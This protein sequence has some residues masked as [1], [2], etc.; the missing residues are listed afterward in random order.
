MSDRR[1]SQNRRQGQGA[2]RL[3]RMESNDR[4][5]SLFWCREPGAREISA[6]KPEDHGP[7]FVRGGKLTEWNGELRYRRHHAEQDECIEHQTQNDTSADVPEQVPPPGTG[8][9][10]STCFHHRAYHAAGRG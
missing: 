10:L 3:E 8:K 7:K 5:S 4:V 2:A 1:R 9:R 6:E